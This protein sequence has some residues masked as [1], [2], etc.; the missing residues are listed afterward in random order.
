MTETAPL[1]K[2]IL[3]DMAKERLVEIVLNLQVEIKN[4]EKDFRKIVNLYN[5]Q[6]NQFMM[7]QCNRCDTCDISG[8]PENIVGDALEE[9]VIHVLK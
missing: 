2:E 8:I 4:K 3:T 6:R 7:Q 1:N 9:E 5:L